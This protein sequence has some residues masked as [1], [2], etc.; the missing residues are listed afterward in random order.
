MTES[1]MAVDPA[2]GP[3]KTALSLLWRT[4]LENVPREEPFLVRLKDPAGKYFWD[5]TDGMMDD[6]EISGAWKHADDPMIANA[7]IVGWFPAPMYEGKIAY[8]AV[9]A[10]E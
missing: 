8:Q 6:G 9:I 4:D 3:D 1:L 5:M 2:D 10:N 7:Q